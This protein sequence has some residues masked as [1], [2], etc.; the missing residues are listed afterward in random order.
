M[1]FPVKTSIRLGEEEAKRLRS[2][3]ERGTGAYR[4]E[5]SNDER[6][7]ERFK[8]CGDEQLHKCRLPANNFPGG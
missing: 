6:F 2:R 3:R 5:H 1:D 7:A 4:T 8:L